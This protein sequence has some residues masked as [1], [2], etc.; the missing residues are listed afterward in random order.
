VGLCSFQFNDP[1]LA[2]VNSTGSPY[3]PQGTA[4]PLKVRM[5]DLLGR[6]EF[7]DALRDLIWQ[8][9]LGF[10]KPDMGFSLPWVLHVADTGALQISRSYKITGIAA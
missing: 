3:L 8:C 2:L 7:R 4:S 9:D 6:G 5:V 1:H 10:T